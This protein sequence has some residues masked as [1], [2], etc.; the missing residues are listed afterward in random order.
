M[1]TVVLSILLLLTSII[2]A[3]AQGPIYLPLVINRPYY[4][5]W[6]NGSDEIFDSRT[7]A[8][9][10][11]TVNDDRRVSEIRV[12]LDAYTSYDVTSMV[13][14][15]DPPDGSYYY[16]IYKSSV[17]TVQEGYYRGFYQTWLYNSAP[18][19]PVQYCVVPC[20]GSYT[21]REPLPSGVLAR[22]VWTLRVSSSYPG[23]LERFTLGLV[24]IG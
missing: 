3:Q 20:R 17:G 22:G 12:N 6:T 18:D 13:V 4:R 8:V 7:V 23:R 1:K 15:L 16:I 21:P 9:S 10:T 14:R 5:T 2:P 24:F 11:I 19:G